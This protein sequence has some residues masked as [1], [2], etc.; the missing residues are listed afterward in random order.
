MMAPIIL[1]LLSFLLLLLPTEV[2]SSPAPSP[3]HLGY[4]ALRVGHALTD[5]ELRNRDLA[6]DTLSRCLS[7]SFPKPSTAENSTTATT[8]FYLAGNSTEYVQTSQPFNLNLP[9]QPVAIVAPTTVKDVATALKC[10]NAAGVKVAARGGGH[11]YGAMGLGGKNGSLVLDMVKFNAIELGED[12]VVSVGTGV[13]LGNLASALAEKG[14]ALPHG[15]CPGVGVA[16]HALHGGFGFASRL[17]GMTLDTI[18][19]LD[20]VLA[21]GTITSASETKNP[22]LFWAL[23]GAGSSFAIVTTIHL[24]TKAVPASGLSYTVNIPSNITSAIPDRVNAFLAVQNF[25]LTAPKELALRVLF[26]P[27]VDIRLTGV[28]WGDAAEFKSVMAPLLKSLPGAKVTSNNQTWVKVLQ[29]LANGASLQQ[30]LS[31][32]DKHETL[33]QKSLS[34]T[35]THPL[36]SKHLTSFFRFLS[37]EGKSASLPW[38]IFCDLF[39]GGNSAIT[40]VPLSATSYTHRS[41]SLFTFQ[42]YANTRTQRPPFPEDGLI[43]LDLMVR[44]ITD[45]FDPE[46]GEVIKGYANYNDPRLDAEE[47]QRMYYGEE[48]WDGSMGGESVVERLRRI[49]RMV[50]PERVI[51]NPQSFGAEPQA[52]GEGHDH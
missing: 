5:R 31:G 10:A 27:A 11:S 28:W 51:W 34:T 20:I 17:W 52:P 37:N 12:G 8:Q 7:L 3:F 49:K 48:S 33:Y 2:L 44:S 30:P 22:E 29:S 40:S 38:Y 46:K 19:S 41:D 47:A 16:G 15:I 21:N 35:S 6:A 18:V 4:P 1:P 14:R 9:Y 43:F 39:G 24:Q 32:Y 25:S 45:E 50:D 26:A 36:T 42:F 13:R 23:R